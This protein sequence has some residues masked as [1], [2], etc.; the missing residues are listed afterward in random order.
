MSRLRHRS[1]EPF[2]KGPNAETGNELQNHRLE[3]ESLAGDGP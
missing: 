1:P 2:N 3:V